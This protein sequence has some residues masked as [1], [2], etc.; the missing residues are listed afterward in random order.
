[1][2]DFAGRRVEC[3]DDRTNHGKLMARLQAAASSNG[4]ATS[5][6]RKGSRNIPCSSAEATL[7]RN[8]PAITRYGIVAGLRLDP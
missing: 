7:D 2:R 5:H 1:M 3:D 4:R 6:P 8:E